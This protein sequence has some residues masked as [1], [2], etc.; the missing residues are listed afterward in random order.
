MKRI[1]S[2]ILIILLLVPSQAFAQ[3]D[4][5]SELSMEATDNSIII[6]GTPTEGGK[7]SKG[8][9]I[10]FFV[11]KP[12]CDFNALDN[13]E[14]IETALAYME[15]LINPPEDEEFRFEVKFNDSMPYGIYTLKVSVIKQDGETDYASYRYNR[16][17]S[18]DLKTAVNAF[19]NVTAENFGKVSNEYIN[20]KLMF[21]V[22]DMPE[23]DGIMN[24]LGECFILARDGLSSGETEGK[25][26][27]LTSLA[28]V[29]Y[30]MG[31]AM[32]LYSVLES[33]NEKVYEKYCSLLPELLDA[34]ADVEKMNEIYEAIANDSLT[35]AEK[36]R[37]IRISTGLSYIKGGT[38]EEVSHALGTYAEVLDVDLEYLEENDVAISEIARYINTE[39]ILQYA[40]GMREAVKEAAE[41][42]IGARKKPQ[43]SSGSSS[44]GG[45]GTVAYPSAEVQTP[46][47]VKEEQK[48]EF[49]F[50][51]IK[52]L[53]WAK[54]AIMSLYKKGIVNGVSENSFE[55]VRTVTREE[56]VKLAVTSFGLEHIEK[57][58]VEF[59]DCTEDKWFYPYVQI[60]FANELISGMGDGTFGA[61]Q[62]IKR[63]DVAVICLK[64]LEMAGKL[65]TIDSERAFSDG[66]EISGYAKTAVMSLSQIGV[67]SGF[68]D[69]TFR[70][71]E[72]TTRAQ[73]AVIIER[74]MSLK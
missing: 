42:I 64:L 32:A 5:K 49:V 50:G 35:V 66:S 60:A 10:S 33:G 20:E 73:A 13:E 12:G 3:G 34:K 54:D 36:L 31:A 48:T 18:E 58:P 25:I 56:F 70:P 74:M 4:L 61:G 1:I 72:T 27:E 41:T 11:L 29:K 30:C 71:K 9:Y 24:D 51:D 44:G 57:E 46:E 16:A 62:A 69:G 22:S 68:E 45:G 65:P 37:K 39:S 14:D 28:D 40:D 59:T 7:L 19:K 6:K 23:F 47:S 67:I 17:S 15:T 52:D 8:D 53:A 26:T 2:I 38:Y 21:D 63:E 43:G 55:P